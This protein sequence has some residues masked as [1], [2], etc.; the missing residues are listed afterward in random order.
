MTRGAFL[1]KGSG[2]AGGGG[3]KDREG[4]GSVKVGGS[5]WLD[6]R[7]ENPHPTRPRKRTNSSEEIRGGEGKE[8]G[9]G[10]EL[11]ICERPFPRR[12]KIGWRIKKERTRL[13][14]G[15]GTSSI[16]AVKGGKLVLSRV[17]RLLRPP[18]LPFFRE[19]LRRGSFTVGVSRGEA[20]VGEPLTGGKCLQLRKIIVNVNPEKT[21]TNSA[22]VSPSR[23]EPTFARSRHN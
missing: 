12:L 20:Q 18:A 22:I 1:A 23:S 15:C 8:P 4:G 16:I 19:F 5:L 11:C 2:A 13:R 6:T 9:T 10:G 7:G 21:S 3:G 14:R 17:A